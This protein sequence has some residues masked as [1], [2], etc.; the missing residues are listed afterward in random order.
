MTVKTYHDSALTVPVNNENP[1]IIYIDKSMT[2]LVRYPVY[3]KNSS[4]NY[5]ATVTDISISVPTFTFNIS[6]DNFRTGETF[7]VDSAPL[8]GFERG[9][10]SLYP[11]DIL[12]NYLI[13]KV[14][15]PPQG[16]WLA[17]SNFSFNL[18]YQYSIFTTF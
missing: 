12:M 8:C 3:F 13:V 5:V 17:P 16:F 14:P 7:T 4:D 10:F 15:T 18:I 2:D 9:Q 11:Q 1:I 6:N